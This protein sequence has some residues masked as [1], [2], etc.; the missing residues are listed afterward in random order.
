MTE[1]W[2]STCPVCKENAKMKYTED[3]SGYEEI[4]VDCVCCDELFQLAETEDGRD[5]WVASL[6]RLG[7]STEGWYWAA[8]AWDPEIEEWIFWRWGAGYFNSIKSAVARAEENGWQ[9][10]CKP[11]L[12]D[13]LAYESR[14]R[15]HE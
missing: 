2:A 9:G 4:V 15:R 12:V 8:V 14:G 6:L 7:R 13:S 11:V 5:V 1:S 10:Y 3:F